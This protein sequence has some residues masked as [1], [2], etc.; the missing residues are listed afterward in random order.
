MDGHHDFIILIDAL[1]HDYLTPEGTPYLYSLKQQGVHA[2]VTE[3]YAFQ[4]RP[5]FFAGLEPDES[6]VCTLYEYNVHDSPFAFLRPYESFLSVIDSLSLDR[7][8]RGVIR[9]IAKRHA[10]KLGHHAAA[11]VMGTEQIPLSLL[12][13]FAL[14]EK[15]YTD[16]TD[17]FAPNLT[18]FDLLRQ[19]N[20]TWAWIGYPRH[21]G[22]SESILNAYYDAEHADVVYLHF[23]ELDWIGHQYGPDSRERREA[24]TKIDQAVKSLL[25]PSLKAG[26]RAVIFGDHGMVNV[27]YQLNLEKV[28]KKLPLK[29]P[30]DYLYFL[31]STQ[32]RFWFSSFS[33]ERVVR[34]ALEGVKGGHIL[35]DKERRELHIDFKHRKYGDLFFAVDGPGIIH[36]SFFSRNGDG[37]KGMHGY[38]PHV[39]DNMTQVIVAGEGVSCE[40]R[41]TLRMVKI[42]N[43]LK[44]FLLL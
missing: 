3:T 37:P 22:S 1:R 14:S 16:D 21:F 28:L 18:F 29:V 24:L 15:V 35:G 33:A 39:K 36:P 8:F 9:R 4:T 42:C 30:G 17:A 7:Y 34:Q 13:F 6:Q 5:A 27:E 19:K 23:S 11:D 43:L 25:V 44:E 32:A 31:D 2:T 26:K 40:E 38:L 20:K 12:S 41:G 10:K